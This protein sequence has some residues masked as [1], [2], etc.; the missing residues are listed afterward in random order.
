MFFMDSLCHRRNSLPGPRD[1]L[2]NAQ[3]GI[4]ECGTGPQWF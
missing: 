3:E 1:C 4:F 2:E